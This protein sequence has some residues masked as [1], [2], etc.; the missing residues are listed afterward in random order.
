MVADGHGGEATGTL[1]VTVVDPTPPTP[2]LETPAFGAY[3]T[4]CVTFSWSTPDT[5]VVGWTLT[6][7]DNQ[8]ETVEHDVAGTS[9]EMCLDGGPYTWSV[10]GTDLSGQAGSAGPQPV[11]VD[12]EGPYPFALTGQ[13]PADAT[14][15]CADAI[16]LSWEAANDAGPQ[17]GVGLDQLPYEVWLDGVAQHPRVAETSFVV[18]APSDGLHEWFV[19]AYDDL[20][21]WTD[22]AAE[23]PVG[24]FGIDCDPPAMAAAWSGV[25]DSSDVVATG[26]EPTPGQPLRLRVKGQLCGLCG[27]GLCVDGTVF[28][29]QGDADGIELSE[30]TELN[31]SGAGALSVWMD[32]DAD[33]VTER[34]QVAALAGAGAG[35]WFPANGHRSQNATPEFEWAEPTEESTVQVW[36][37]GELWD[38][39]PLDDGEHTWQLVVSDAATNSAPNPEVT[40]TID[41][42]PPEPFTIQQP[43]NWETIGEGEA[44][45]CW[46]SAVDETTGIAGYTVV[47]D[48]DVAATQTDTCL[49]LEGLADGQHCVTVMAMDAV[50]LLRATEERCFTVDTNGPG[51]PPGLTPVDGACLGTQQVTFGWEACVDDGIGVLEVSL[52]VDDEQRE[53]LPPSGTTA[54]L[55]LDEGDHTWFVRCTDA[56]GFETDSEIHTLTIDLTAPAIERIE[57]FADYTVRIEATD[58]AC[59]VATVTAALDEDDLA[60]ALPSD[61]GGYEIGL[62][63][64][65]D[66]DH[67]LRVRVQDAVGHV[68]D[69]SLALPVGE[70]WAPTECDAQICAESRTGEACGQGGLCE[71]GECRLPAVDDGPP[72]DDDLGADDA[73]AEDTAAAPDEGPGKGD[74]PIEGTSDDGGCQAGGTG[75]P[76]MWILLLWPLLRRRR[77][78]VV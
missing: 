73:G 70:C 65:E 61:D 74:A 63:V 46:Q 2:T 77:E 30:L 47:L 38:G 76:P 58:A 36:V 64:P 16:T 69:G 5:D 8:G 3:V 32:E 9:L 51:L 21:N 28:A 60:E 67:T 1:T 6:I 56:A 7:E 11:F 72:R 55:G 31:A 41:T 40:W 71:D 68:T 34:I 42:T 59:G 19:R 52:W 27:D 20:G 22:A 37:D 50:G 29:A 24:S 17:G 10:S 62:E 13:S 18:E 15:V 44:L 39:E 54:V 53:V 25:L 57:V 12:V 23:P 4:D 14:W 66:G 49:L 78:E 33:C 75:A 43:A 45:V 35:P 48:E 26:L